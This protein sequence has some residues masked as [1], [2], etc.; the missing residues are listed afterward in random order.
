MKLLRSFFANIIGL[1]GCKN[2]KQSVLEIRTFFNIYIQ[3]I[4]L[5]NKKLIKWKYIPM[6]FSDLVTPCFLDRILM[7]FQIGNNDVIV[8]LYS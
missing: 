6:L 4:K 1:P 2:K 8:F 3:I 7:S 5:L